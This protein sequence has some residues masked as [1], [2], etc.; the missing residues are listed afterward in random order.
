MV[1]TENVKQHIKYI[2]KLV[3]QAEKNL[4]KAR[5]WGVYDI[6]NGKT[7]TGIIKHNKI[8]KTEKDLVNINKELK[9]LQDELTSLDLKVNTKVNAGNLNK[10]L[11]IFTDNIF[12]DVY[13]QTKITTGL[14]N[15]SN[16]KRSLN[17]LYEDINKLN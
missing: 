2:L 17:N 5:N 11:D 6:L 8:S 10:F 3:D 9:I 1:N 14:D 7:L 13:T 4:K 16:L 12:S 15:I